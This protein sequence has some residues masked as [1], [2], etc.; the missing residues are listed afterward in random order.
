MSFV[1]TIP[2]V[3]LPGQ[4]NAATAFLD[5]HPAEGCGTQTAI[6]YEGET[7]TYNQFDA[8]AP[9]GGYGREMGHAVLD[10]Y[11][12]VKTAWIKNFDKFTW[13]SVGAGF[14]C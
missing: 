13:T 7:Y 10:A 1:T 12:Q 9:F 8:A 4:F 6:S 11:T 3:T 14:V 2:T 5:R